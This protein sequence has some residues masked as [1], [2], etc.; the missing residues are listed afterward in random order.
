MFIPEENEPRTSMSLRA[1]YTSTEMYMDALIP[2]SYY[3]KKRRKIR[4]WEEQNNE[5]ARSTAPTIRELIM[6]QSFLGAW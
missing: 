6:D 4:K 3:W 5:D 1:L 2:K